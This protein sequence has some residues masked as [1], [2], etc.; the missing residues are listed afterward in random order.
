MVKLVDTL[1]S[2]TSDRKIVEV[3]VLFRASKSQ[4]GEIQSAGDQ[5]G[6][7][8]AQSGYNLPAYSFF[9]LFLIILS[10]ASLPVSID[11][12]TPAGL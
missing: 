2:G 7:P 5:A 12:G 11:M 8:A 3:R 1:V 9:L 6:L 10:A 4:S